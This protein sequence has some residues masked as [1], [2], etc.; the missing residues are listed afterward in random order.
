M[1]KLVLYLRYISISLKTSM[2]YKYSFITHLFIQ[3]FTY[4]TNYLGIWV[5]LK[6]FNTIH[7]WSYYEVVF[8]C[9]LNLLSYGICAVFIADPMRSVGNMV[10]SGD[11]DSMLIRPLNPLY[12]LIAKNFTYGFMGHIALSLVVFGIC[13]NHL[14]I[15]WSVAN[16]IWI[17]LDL[18]GAIL[19]QSAMF[20]L[21][22]SLSFWIM[23]SAQV[24]Y[25]F[26]FGFRRF[27]DYPIS[28]YNS[29]LR[30]ILTFIIPYA[31][32]NFYPSI[33]FLN[34]SGDTVFHPILQYGTP[35]VGVIFIVVAYKIWTLGIKHYESSGS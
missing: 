27:I 6:K 12:H 2:E 9:S 4:S 14:N 7:G 17:V 31:F 10:I 13:L 29:F 28:I 25:S 15:S 8:L 1:D 35:I 11:F 18:L 20:I 21:G 19:I 23:N 34:K 3:I 5:L 32:V 16:L 26:T 22:G 30:V 24:V 33:Y